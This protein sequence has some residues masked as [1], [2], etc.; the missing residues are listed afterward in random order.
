MVPTPF[1]KN[2]CTRPRAPTVLWHTL[3]VSLSFY[4]VLDQSLLILLCCELQASRRTSFP[5]ILV[6]A[7]HLTIGSPGSKT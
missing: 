4:L 5:V 3:R 6:S 1:K 2:V 7:S